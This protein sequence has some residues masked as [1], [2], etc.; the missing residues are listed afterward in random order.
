MPTL[1]GVMV[2]PFLSSR[3][4]G[5]I[6]G[7]LLVAAHGFAIAKSGDA[8]AWLKGFPRSKSI[9]TTLLAIDAIWA[10][11][12]IADMDLGE[13]TY[14]RAKLLIVVVVA[15]FLTWK[16]VDEFLAV[17]ALGMLLLLVAEPVLE[18]T[19]LRP[20]TS[21]LFLVVLAYAWVVLGMFWVGMPYLLRDQIGWLGKSDS[22][23]RMACG[24]GV[25]YGVLLLVCA[26][27]QNG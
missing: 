17:R 21:R 12:L 11:L 10:F 14:L 15:T 7:V 3:V 24:A 20:E 26:V 18:A 4:V 23:W 2:Y 13:F 8:R 19:F 6:L 22:R 9:G 25:I 27:A 16:F 5:L 1:R